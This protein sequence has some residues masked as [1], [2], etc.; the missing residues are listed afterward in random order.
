MCERAMRSFFLTIPLFV[1]TYLK[2]E[3]NEPVYLCWCFLV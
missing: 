3:G 1:S 2:R